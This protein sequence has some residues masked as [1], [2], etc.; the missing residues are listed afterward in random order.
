MPGLGHAGG[1]E[2]HVAAEAAAQSA[3]PW[4]NLRADLRWG[5]GSEYRSGQTGRQAVCRWLRGMPSQRTRSCQGP[6]QA[7]ALFVPATALCEQ[8]ELGLGAHLLSG[9][10]RWS[11]ARPIGGRRGQAV[12]GCDHHVA[13]PNPS[14]RAG[15]G[16]LGRG[17]ARPQHHRFGPDGCGIEIEA[18]QKHPPT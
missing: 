2:S 12:A 13:V 5:T 3:C 16:A 7:Y 6:L 9:V 4:R 15:A 17:G 14:A 8:F 18:G 10:R 11:A 1:V